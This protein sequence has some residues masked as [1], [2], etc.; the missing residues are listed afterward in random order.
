MLTN[1]DIYIDA[2]GYTPSLNDISESSHGF[3]SDSSRSPRSTPTTSHE[4]TD[5]SFRIR[6]LSKLDHLRRVILNEE[7]IPPSKNGRIIPLNFESNYSQ[8]QI[9]ER[10]KKPY[11]SN[12][13]TSSIYTTYSFFPRQIYAQLSKIANLYFF[14]VSILQMIPSW[15][16]TGTY[17]T[18][19]PLCVFIGIS[20]GREAYDDIRRHRQDKEENNRD[21]TVL[22]PLFEKK[23]QVTHN[24]ETDFYRVNAVNSSS[25]LSSVEDY[26]INQAGVQNAGSSLSKKQIMW[27]DLKVGEVIEIKRDEWVP[28]DIVLL[29]AKGS[30]ESVY[31]ETMDLDGE[32]TLKSREAHPELAKHCNSYEKLRN[33]KAIV[34]TEDPNND[35]YNFEGMV[36]IRDESSR[37]EITY[38][39]NSD[40]VIYRGSILRNTDS[41]LG[42]VIFTGEET[43][44]RMNSIKNPRT[45]APKLQKKINL[46]ILFM[47][48]I[49]IILA[50]IWTVIAKVTYN[51]KGNKMWYLDGLEVTVVQNFMGYIIMYNTLIPLSLYVSM[52]IIKVMQIFLMEWDIDMYH[53]ESNTRCEAK[54]ATILEELGQVSYIFSDKTGTLTDNLMVFRKISAAGIAWLHDIDILTNGRNNLD[55]EDDQDAITVA[56]TAANAANTIQNARGRS[57]GTAILPR[58]SVATVGSP[59]RSMDPS[60]VARK[61]QSS[62]VYTGRPSMAGFVRNSISSFHSN[63][64]TTDNHRLSMASSSHIS[65]WRSTA[66]PIKPQEIRSTLDLILYIQTHPNTVYTKKVKFFL[67]S[68]SLC[69][70]CLPKKIDLNDDIPVDVNSEELDSTI[71]YQS[72][73]PDE[74]ALVSAARDMGFILSDKKMKLLT[75]RT[76]PNGFDSD[77]ID[78][79][80][81]ILDIIEFTSSRKKMSVIVKFPDGRICVICKG[82][83]NVMLERLRTNNLAKGKAAE[84]AKTATERRKSEAEFVMQR[85]S[86]DQLINNNN[87]SGKSV[88]SLQRA[89]SLNLNRRKPLASIDG[90]LSNARNEDIQIEGIASTSRRSVSLSRAKRFGIETKDNSDEN[91]VENNRLS[92]TTGIVSP[93]DLIIDDK[94]VTNGEYILEK[95]LE[96]IEEFS[97]EGLRTLI[98]AYRWMDKKEYESWS[99]KYSDAKKSLIDRKK[100]IGEIGELVEHG[101]ELSGATAIEDKLQEGVAEAIDKLRRAGIKIW[102]LTGDKRET[103]INIGHSCRLVKDYSTVIVLRSDDDEDLETKMSAAILEL[104][105]GRIAH[106]VA[107]IDGGTLA[108]VEN[109]VAMKSMF[110]DLGIR[111]DSVIVCRASPSQKANMVSAIREKLKDKV[112]LAIGDGANDIAMIQSA[113]IGIGITGKEGLQAARSSD[114]SIAQFRYLLKLLFVHGRYNYIRTSKYVLSTFYKEL[115]FYL[116]QAIFQRNT[117]WTG[118]SLYEPWSLSMF[119]TLFST[120]PV[121]CIGMFEKDLKPATLIAIPELYQKGITNSG[122]NLYIFLGWSLLAASQSVL[123]SFTSWYLY[124]IFE[125][126]DNSLFPL[127]TL[128]YTIIVAVINLKIQFLEMHSRS[129]TSFLTS[130]ISIGGWLIWNLFIS[131]LYKSRESKIYHVYNSMIKHFGKELSWWSALLVITTM[132]I[133]LDIIITC[134]RTALFPTDTDIF[135]ELEQD[136]NVRRRLEIEAFEEMKQGWTW[137]RGK[138]DIDE[139]NVSEKSSIASVE[140]DDNVRTMP[141]HVANGRFYDI[142]GRRKRAT[143]DVP[144]IHSEEM[145]NDNA[146]SVSRGN[147]STIRRLGSHSKNGSDSSSTIFVRNDKKPRPLSEGSTNSDNSGVLGSGI[148]SSLKSINETDYEMEYLP[149]GKAIKHR[150]S[151]RP[152]RADKLKK[153]LRFGTQE[154]FEATAEDEREIEEILELRQQQLQQ[155]EERQ[156]DERREQKRSHREQ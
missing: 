63:I 10:T 53:V 57:E 69:H 121:W 119:N 62:T 120:L 41:V 60:F 80:Y 2:I 14:C 85:K 91:R 123:V 98:Y 129:I 131:E 145:Q 46:I 23:H 75:I 146:S 13:I 86:L 32:T 115:F 74:L 156:R 117:L 144:S 34:T 79:I 127:G 29:T 72:A 21:V 103:A 109:D 82:A 25:Q 101:F 142:F 35:L 68:I 135:Q 114:Y 138:N 24:E 89:A 132:T 48:I 7:Q 71:E 15:S 107:V 83:D 9:D 70:E 17:T 22:R 125:Y 128:T 38:P 99:L 39:L 65:T 28:A 110:I 6:I 19:I 92:T 11:I 153:K 78:E 137:P 148:M 133:L 102:M 106:C 149:S 143:S 116:S 3:S 130:I 5:I 50:V 37:Q 73:S 154:S 126:K 49:V 20:M 27:K 96:H 61:G 52:E 100:K 43:K 81:E 76:Y 134:F 42:L 18:I 95:T 104:D 124:G 90:Y 56:N 26:E 84:V 151:N 88:S 77:P 12:M 118:T 66:A 44:I 47:V 31:I 93:E 16:T 1:D 140:M 40:H 94:L 55:L 54:T 97:S 141:R 136:L 4:S 30:S 8:P 113:D 64:A 122:F 87:N 33:I 111:C 152:S 45:K 139:E 112:T 51:K 147:A 105:A 67:L 150:K 58:L 59:R 108:D 36:S 155:E